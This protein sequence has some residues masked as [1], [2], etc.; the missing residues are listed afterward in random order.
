M[1]ATVLAGVIACGLAV[2]LHE[3]RGDEGVS[4]E[5]AVATA[6]A[7]DLC[8]ILQ[9]AFLGS[10]GDGLISTRRD[11]AARLRAADAIRDGQSTNT[12]RP[13]ARDGMDLTR[14]R[15]LENPP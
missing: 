15:P 14:A 7:A 6:I 2:L 9:P 4:A 5:R 10:T 3:T 11:A 1:S 8:V 12:M 13:L